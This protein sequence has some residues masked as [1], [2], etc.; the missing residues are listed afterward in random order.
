MRTVRDNSQNSNHDIES[1]KHS[2][3]Q[4]QLESRRKKPARESSGSMRAP[5]PA[6]SQ[7][8]MQGTHGGNIGA[9]GAGMFGFGP[10]IPLGAL[11]DTNGAASTLG[12]SF[13]DDSHLSSVNG[14]NLFNA[15]RQ[16]SLPGLSAYGAV[17]S[18]SAQQ[19]AGYATPT[20][21]Y[22]QY[23]R[24]ITNF[25][26]IQSS[27]NDQSADSNLSSL[28]SSFHVGQAPQQIYQ[29]AAQFPFTTNNYDPPT[30]SQTGFHSYSSSF[31]QPLAPGLQTPSQSRADSAIHAAG[32]DDNLPSID[33]TTYFD[34]PR[35]SRS[36]A[37][38]PNLSPVK[39]PDASVV[40]PL[41]PEK[42]SLPAASSPTPWAKRMRLSLPEGDETPSS[43]AKLAVDA[44]S[45]GAFA[46]GEGAAGGAGI[47]RPAPV[48]APGA[49]KF[50]SA[51][52]L[53][54]SVGGD[55]LEGIDWGLVDG[56]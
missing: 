1:D 45:E 43:P 3:G 13:P 6:H 30:A 19:G 34:Y 9:A 26:G 8:W 18:W 20:V 4:Q 27:L 2:A 41:E 37:A 10:N 38:T 21:S 11:T 12:R 56:E 31:N 51:A 47:A 28:P 55:E 53:E 46:G 39:T 15:Y 32:S 35:L 7:I 33:V 22:G 40:D 44:G 42:R 49:I 14:P 25:G 36:Y 16:Q 17:S 23:P 50:P 29:S 5:A 54:G 24:A 52:A 48:I